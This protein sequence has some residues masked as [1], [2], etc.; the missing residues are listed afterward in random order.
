MCGGHIPCL[1]RSSFSCIRS[2]SSRSRFFALSAYSCLSH[3]FLKSVSP[4]LFVPEADM[5]EEE[6]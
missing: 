1:M 3:F 6:S 4:A 2:F 5:A